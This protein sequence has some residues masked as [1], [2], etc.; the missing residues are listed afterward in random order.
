MKSGRYEYYQPNEKN[1]MN[2]AGDCSI[3]TLTKI[4][5]RGWKESFDELAAVA[6]EEQCMPNTMLCIRKF[7]ES[8]GF[9]Y[10]RMENQGER[11]KKKTVKEFA[12]EHRIGKYILITKN[13]MLALI[14]GTYYDSFD[15]GFMGIEGVWSESGLKNKEGMIDEK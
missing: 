15:S 8:R 1:G 6:R 10:F 3:R 2:G 13:H 4:L 5:G 12:S 9:V 14:D 11:R 7:L